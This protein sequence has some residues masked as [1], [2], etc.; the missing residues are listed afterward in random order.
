MMCKFFYIFVP[1][2]REEWGLLSSVVPEG[3]VS[4]PPWFQHVR[5][6][7]LDRPSEPSTVAFSLSVTW[8]EGTVQTDFLLF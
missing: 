2:K 8:W 1:T 5:H 7:L 3:L 4:H 6:H